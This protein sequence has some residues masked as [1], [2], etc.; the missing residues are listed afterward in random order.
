[1]AVCGNETIE[2][3]HMFSLPTDSRPCNN[4]CHMQAE[5]LKMSLANIGF[6]IEREESSAKEWK[7][8]S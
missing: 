2:M 6:S 5:K 8:Y 1:M 3:N 4:D 7:L